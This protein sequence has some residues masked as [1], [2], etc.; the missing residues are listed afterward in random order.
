M[1]RI[2]QKTTAAHSTIA[3]LLASALFVSSS[4]AWAEDAKKPKTANAKTTSA[5]VVEKNSND[6]LVKGPHGLTVT[7]ADV[8]S[9]VNKMP[10]DN[11]PEFFKNK[12]L[13]QQVANNLL[14]RRVLAKEASTEK[15]DQDEVVKAA[16]N[17]AK[18]RVM[19][20]AR[21]N[22]MDAR[23]E[24][25]PQAIEA[26]ARNTYNANIQQYETPAQT[27][28]SHILIEK[29]DDKSMALA[30]DVLNKLKSGGKFEDLAK[31][32]SKDPGSAAR[33]G[34]L[35]FFGQGRMV[36]PFEDAVNALTKPGDLSGLVESQFGYHIIRLDERKPKAVKSFDE[37]KPSLMAESR[38]AILSG[39]RIQ[40]VQGISAQ[41]Q[42]DKEAIDKLSQEGT[43][44]VSAK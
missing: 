41:M 24:P 22:Q 44:A 3:G 25:T 16:L 5:K 4:L 7:V 20:D 9:E 17:V 14:V 21:L 8:L 38:T 33:G 15:L 42:F 27:R 32:F 37:V 6:I 18:D 26:Y 23:N 11:R 34:D 2:S 40:M 39:K 10:P 19:S 35:G 13:I 29:S 1:T 43:S 28:A 30:Q 36:K 12:G 31:E